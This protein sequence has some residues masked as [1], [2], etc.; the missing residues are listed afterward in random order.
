M[1][2]PRASARIRGKPQAE[3]ESQPTIRPELAAE[4]GVGA[5][6]LVKPEP[7]ATL[8]PVPLTRLDME[9]ADVPPEK[10]DEWMELQG[11]VDFYKDDPEDE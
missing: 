8:K 9:L 11:I 4:P 5:E 10:L 2:K 1:R 3:P 7:T 6:P